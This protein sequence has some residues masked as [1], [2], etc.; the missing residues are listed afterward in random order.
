VTTSNVTKK[1]EEMNT[2]INVKETRIKKERQKKYVVFYRPPKIK[3]Q[4]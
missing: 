4:N 2:E 1:T 3:K